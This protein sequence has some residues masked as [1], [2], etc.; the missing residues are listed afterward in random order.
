MYVPP[1]D[2]IHID[3]NSAVPPHDLRV[4]VVSTSVNLDGSCRVSM[5]LVI[6]NVALVVM[7]PHERN[8]T[9]CKAQND[10]LAQPLRQA[11]TA[12]SIEVLLLIDCLY[13]HSKSKTQWCLMTQRAS[14]C[15]CYLAITAILSPCKASSMVVVTPTISKLSKY[16][17]KLKYC[18]ERQ[19]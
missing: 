5:M 13:C 17:I 16:L 4:P 6:L 7:V 9:A 3:S 1:R 8:S 19:Q 14:H 11:L 12:R 10:G 18:K 2:S 15:D